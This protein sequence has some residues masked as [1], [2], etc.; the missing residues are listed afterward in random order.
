MDVLR[1]KAALRRVWLPAVIAF[2]VVVAGSFVYAEQRIPPSAQASVAVRDALTVNT[3]GNPS[4]AVSFDAIIESDR[5]ATMVRHELGPRAGNVKGALSVSTVLPASGINISP[6]FLVKAKAK[7]LAL[8][9][10][11]VNAAITQG[12]S[13]YVQL[14][15]VGSSQ[16]RAQVAAEVQAANSSLASAMQAYDSFVSSSGGDR[17]AQISALSAEIGALTTQVALARAAGASG[18]STDG[19][20]SALQ[21]Q[22]DS[23]EQQLSNLEPIQAEYQ[24]LASALSSAQTNVQQ[25][26][27]LQEQAAASQAVPIADQVK[28]LDRAVPSSSSLLKTLVYALGFVLGLLAAL[29]IVYAEAALQTRTPGGRDLLALLELP[30]LG[31]I[32][33]H[34]IPRGVR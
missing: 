32:P 20:A 26:T 18:A 13:L 19:V 16:A 10:A 3:A 34:A 31:R 9:E 23:A 28:I 12:R 6:M 17:S 15:S 25:L 2:V 30:A 27:G 24:Q 4:A 22:L 11:I 29:G 7:T 5:L 21:A 8:A 33:A 1:F 14:N